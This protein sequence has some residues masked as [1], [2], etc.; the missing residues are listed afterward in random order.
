VSPIGEVTG[1]GFVITGGGGGVGSAVAA[2]LCRLGAGV[3]VCGRTHGTLDA[4]AAAVTAEL[5][6]GHAFAVEC[7]CRDPASV[8]TM[9][10]TSWELLGRVDGLINNASGLFPARAE[11]I[12]RT[13]S[14]R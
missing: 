2:E 13:A 8:E 3:V 6:P 11:A 10:D 1:R 7:D 14:R 9:A 12:S 4:T 5:G